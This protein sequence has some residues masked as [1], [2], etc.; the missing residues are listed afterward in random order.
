MKECFKRVTNVMC[1]ES[2]EQFEKIS[3]SRQTIAL[4]IEVLEISIKKSLTSKAE[5]IALY[6]LTIDESIDS[7]D[8]AQVAVLKRGV[9]ES[10]DVTEELASIVSL[11]GTAKGSDLLEAVMKT[12]NG[13]KLNLNNLCGVITNE[14][15]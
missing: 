9:D 8:T 14:A 11:K 12:L 1:T 7:K 5:V 13:L 10:F 3:L 4:C 2:K 6:S 15:P